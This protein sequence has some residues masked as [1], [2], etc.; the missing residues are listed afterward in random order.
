MT[1]FADEAVERFVLDSR[2]SAATPSVEELRRGS[3][4]RA[5]L[6]PEGP[7][8]PARDEVVGGVPVRVFEQDTTTRIV[9][10]HGGGFVL[11]DLDTHDALCRRLAAAT[12][13]TV[14]SVAYR[15]AP[16]HPYPAAVDDALAVLEWAGGLGP[17]A[18]GGDSA[19]AFVAVLAARRTPI[20]LKA[21][22]LLCPVVDITFDQPSAEK[23]GIGYTLDIPTLRQWVGW[24]ADAAVPNPLLFDL[25]GMPPALVVAAE[26]D[27]LRD[28]AE[29]YARRLEAAGVPVAFR[30]EPGLVHNFSTITHLSRAAAD[31][32]ARF[33]TDAAA[34]LG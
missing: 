23:Y 34:I 28:G 11:G 6:R 10:L 32:D 20:A 16:E 27:P 21:Q 17:V 7:A 29:R 5:H 1:I 8:M 14:V 19:G 31:A 30:V 9:Y 3:R 15:L 12:R 18:V 22:L 26:L 13:T 24:W 33:L 2:E 25:E 4:E